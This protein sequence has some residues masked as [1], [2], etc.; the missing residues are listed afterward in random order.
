MAWNKAYL[1]AADLVLSLHVALVLF[2]VLGLVLVLCG[3]MLSWSFVGNPWFRMIHLAA[4]GILV[5]QTWLGMTC[6]LTIWEMEL[7]KRAGDATYGG[8]F[9]A[10]WL[11]ELL[12]IQAPAWAFVVAYSAFGLLVL[13]TWFRVR[14]RS[15]FRVETSPRES[16]DVKEP[17]RR[18][19]VP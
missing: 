8:D 17:A 18:P 5:L 4:V 19:E 12:Y 1:I 14:P 16:P 3:K 13:V 2:V 11:D 6:P 9:L 15:L 7:R 10:H